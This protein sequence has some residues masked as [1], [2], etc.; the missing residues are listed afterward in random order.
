MVRAGGLTSAA[1]D[2]FSFTTTHSTG[3]EMGLLLLENDEW[4]LVMHIPADYALDGY[5]LYRKRYL[6]ART[7]GEEE[8]RVARV[9]RLKRV[10]REPPE[11]FQFADTLTML[12]EIAH[13]HG[14]IEFYDEEEG[15]T[16]YGRIHSA[17]DGMITLEMIDADGHAEIDTDQDHVLELISEITF[18]SDY[19][20][21]LYL[22]WKDTRRE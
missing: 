9:L 1:M 4:V 8:H 20:N 22:L 16:F 12:Q 7:A 15:E 21:S 19:L 10:E 11:G 5:K 3:P 18:G 6:T 17:A 2:V 13:D 14:L